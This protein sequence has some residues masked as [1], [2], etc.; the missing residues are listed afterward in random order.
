MQVALKQEIK[1]ALWGCVEIPLY[2][3]MGALRF[4]GT[5]SAF[6]KSL[7]VPLCMAP[8]I[9]IA[10]PNPPPYEDKSVIWTTMLLLIQAYLVVSVFAA[11]LHFFKPKTVTSEQYL[12]C[13]T[14]YN[15]MIVPSFVINIPFILLA[16]TGLNT[17]S[18]VYALMMLTA[19]YSYAFLAFMITHMLQIRWYMGLSFA[20]ADLMFGQIIQNISIYFMMHIS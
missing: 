4:S 7:I 20:V 19:F 6:K 8:L 17:W 3:K 13:I 2:L 9:A 10:T 1:N 14:G 16:V 15:W 12:R 18:D 11:I 5:V